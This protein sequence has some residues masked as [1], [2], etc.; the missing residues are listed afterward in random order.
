MS[1]SETHTVSMPSELWKIVDGHAD[2]N[3]TSRSNVFQD[4]IKNY[5]LND[6]ERKYRIFDIVIVL[7]LFVI[8]LLL[9]SYQVAF[10]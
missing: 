2:S 4:A 3:R 5:L 9:L 8:I 6:K 1:N 10:I 7:L